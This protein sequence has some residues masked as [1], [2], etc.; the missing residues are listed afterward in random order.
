MLSRL[1]IQGRF[2]GLVWPNL[3]S[4]ELRLSLVRLA[5]ASI[6]QPLGL[7]RFRGLQLIFS[8]MCIGVL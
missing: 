5:C 4:G 1:L 2:G 6:V 7:H 8:A 3:A